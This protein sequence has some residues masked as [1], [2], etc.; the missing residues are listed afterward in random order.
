MSHVEELGGLQL[1]NILLFDKAL[2]LSW[3]KRICNQTEGWASF[4][5]YYKIDRA[6]FTVV[7]T[8]KTLKKY[9]K[10]VWVWCPASN[11]VALGNLYPTNHAEKLATPLWLSKE[12]FVHNSKENCSNVDRSVYDIVDAKGHLLSMHELERSGYQ[13]NFIEYNALKI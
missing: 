4:L 13:C 7:L 3:L 10:S 2:K 1:T 12:I 6:I 8:L 9:W 11:K 5:H